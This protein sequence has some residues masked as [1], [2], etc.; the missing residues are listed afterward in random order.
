MIG[1]R[2]KELRGKR[3]QE[4][5]AMKIGVSRARYSH[6]ENG[7]SEPDNET[8]R[9]IADVFNVSTDYLL[10]RTDD[11]EVYK[12]ETPKYTTLELF[13]HRLGNA[14]RDMNNK[15]GNSDRNFV[16]NALG[17]TLDEY[18]KYEQE[19]TIPDKYL[20]RKI[21]KLLQVPIP[22]LLGETDDPTYTEN[23]LEFLSEYD[24]LSLEELQKKYNLTV[25]GKPATQEELEGAL[26]FI[27]SLRSLK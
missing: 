10:G 8:L 3:T 9:K 23:E 7:R 4:E 27:R 14:R 22:Y 19:T 12:D 18:K 21:S 1:E 20:L 11:P 2:L 15:G 16:A 5:I 13:S 6:Y 26:A 17:L 25:D 24:E